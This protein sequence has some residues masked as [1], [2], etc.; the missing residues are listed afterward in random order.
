[1]IFERL[2]CYEVTLVKNYNKPL[3]QKSETKIFKQ[4]RFHKTL[5]QSKRV[6]KTLVF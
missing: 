6:K 1:M 5:V 4:K 2:N 3:I